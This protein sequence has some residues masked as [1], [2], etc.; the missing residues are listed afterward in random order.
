MDPRYLSNFPVN[1]RYLNFCRV[2]GRT[3]DEQCAY[4]SERWKGGSMVGFILWM[5]QQK[6]AF[7]RA[8]PEAFYDPR[9]SW[10]IVDYAAW[11][12]WL[13]QTTDVLEGEPAV[14]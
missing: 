12:R 14:A 8:H 4:D 13:D 7:H 3:P 6:R 9:S 2:H 5:S 11:D 10:A 1:P